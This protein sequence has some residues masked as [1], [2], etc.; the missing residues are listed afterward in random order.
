MSESSNGFPLNPLHENKVTGW[1]A[2]KRL[3]FCRQIH[4]EYSAANRLQSTRP[5][6]VLSDAGLGSG[7]GSVGQHEGRDASA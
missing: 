2:R 3:R 6:R 1:F 7:A 5:D 4:A